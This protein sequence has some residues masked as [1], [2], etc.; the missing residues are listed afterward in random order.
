MGILGVYT[1]MHPLIPLPV[2]GHIC[3]PN[4]CYI[5]LSILFFASFYFVYYTVVYLRMDHESAINK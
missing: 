3:D 2:T 4:F 1:L 5:F